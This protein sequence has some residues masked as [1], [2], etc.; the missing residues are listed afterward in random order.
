[1]A[2]AHL[3]LHTQ[4]SLL[5]GACRLGELCAAAKELGMTSVAMT[6]HG[7]MYGAVE[8]YKAAHDA[9]IKPIL[10]CEVYVA[11]RRLTDKV[12]GPDSERYHLVLLCENETGYRNLIHMVSRAWVDGFYVRPRVDKELLEA[13]HEGLIALSACLAGEIP[14]LL[15]SGDYE[16]AKQTALWYDRVFGRG[17]FYLEMQDHGLPEQQAILPKLMQLSRETGIP[18]VAT[19]D[20]HYIRPSDAKT[21]KVL[22]CIQTNHTIDE[23]TGLEFSTDEFYLKS[24]A[25]MR[26]RF[27]FAPEAVDNTA[28]IAERCCVTFE[29]GKTKLP[30]FE[31]PNGE[32]HFSYFKRQCEAGLQRVCGGEPPAAYNERLSYELSVIREMGYVD[33]FLIVADFI[34]YA[35]SRGIPVGPGRGSGA[36]SLA[37]YCMGITGVDPIRYSLIFERFLNPERV[38]MPDI[39]VDFCYERREEV[40]DYV[41][42]KYGADHV[43]QIVTFGTMAARAAVRDVGRALGIPYA[44]VDGVSKQIPHELGITID[45]ALQ[46]N[47]ELRGM[48][49]RD[50]K[51]RELL[52]TAKRV[53]GMPRHAS[54]HAA[55][56]VI[57]DR[58]VSEYVPLARNDEAVVTQF[59]MTAIEELGLL[60]MDFLGLRTLTVIHD[61]EQMIREKEPDFDIEKIPLTDDATYRMFSKGQTLGVFQCE[62]AGLRSVLTRLRPQSLEDIIAVISLYRPGPMDSIDDYIANRH[63]PQRIRYKTPLLKPIL[64]VTYGCL[65]YQEQV[66]EVFRSLAGYSF[67]RA[68]I[69]RRA[70]SKK[71]HKVMEEER[72]NFIYGLKNADGSTAC[73]G[74]IAN[75]IDER[76]ANSIFDDMSSFAS[77]AFNKSHST[78]YA[79]VAYRTAYLKCHY[80]GEFMAALLTSILDDADKIALYI[81]DCLRLGLRTLPPDVNRSAHAFTPEG[82]GIRFGLLAI[83]NLGKGFIASILEERANNGPFTE[84]YD[85]CKRL[86]GKEFNKRAVEGLIKSGALD[87]LDLN[88]REMLQN[89]PAVTASIEA[90]NRRNLE[91]QLDLFSIGQ[92][93]PVSHA[94]EYVR[95]AEFPQQEL[96]QMEKETTGLYLS[97]HPMAAYADRA[98]QLG[99]ASVAELLEA[100]EEPGAKYRDGS[101]VSL[102]A[103]VTGVKRK[104]TR[105]DDTMAFVTVEDLYGSIELL[106]FPKVYAQYSHLL[107]PG[108]VIYVRGRLSLREDESPKVLPDRIA[109]PPEHPGEGAQ[110][111]APKAKADGPDSEKIEIPAQIREGLYLLIDTMGSPRDKKVKNLLSIFDGQIPVYLCYG[112]TRKKFV[113][114]RGVQLCDP[115]LAE[116]QRLLGKRGVLLR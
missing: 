38:S 106:V 90:E 62:S 84:F 14:R 67:G 72:H 45:K 104:T 32:D 7:N 27:S 35:K 21:Q 114:S 96:L 22:I 66:M 85:F 26:E 39:D 54:T 59:T 52:D 4:Y 63:D 10:G 15:S 98:G 5:D 12:H 2:F 25:E 57:T 103:I 49:D 105:N 115:L 56:V 43:A 81:G 51:I 99:A 69:V 83:K 92:A 8:F 44:T 28:K 77:Y 46:K 34:A 73:C 107:T 71:K 47:P 110:K 50:E 75:G 100:G 33:Y 61:A 94:P 30:R 41:I 60:K 113:T 58:P 65:I 23:D 88:R 40:I 48:Y 9:G 42:R 76:T 18:T 13:H 86:Y 93:H 29:F 89:L 108:S 111:E 68:D 79:I 16:G 82:R 97:G 31:V 95:C 17:N 24:E 11:P 74:C 6:D 80:P 20:V 87:G 64:D 91:G 70:M 1:M 109:L 37:A 102:L 116:L 53:E 55:G 3:H 101:T 78:A 112:D 19:N 36:G